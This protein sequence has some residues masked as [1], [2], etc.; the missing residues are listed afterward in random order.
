METNDQRNDEKVENR[1]TFTS[2][3]IV[4]SNTH[5]TYSQ[6]FCQTQSPIEMSEA[7][8]GLKRRLDFLGVPY[9]K[10]MT[11]DNCCQVINF[12]LKIFPD[13]EVVLCVWH[14]VMR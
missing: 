4:T 10:I 9:P 1:N 3:S 5:S 7:L 13:L 8:R 12:L 6:R 14:F 11:V 2:S